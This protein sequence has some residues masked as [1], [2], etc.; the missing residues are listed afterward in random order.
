MP[1]FLLLFLW[2]H[3][4]FVTISVVLDPICFVGFSV[5]K[6]EDGETVGVPPATQIT[7]LL[8]ILG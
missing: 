4:S 5:C 1:L 8:F 6:G 7:W 2:P 3:C